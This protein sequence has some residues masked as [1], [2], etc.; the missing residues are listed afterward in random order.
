[1]Y[2]QRT[3]AEKIE[4]VGIGLHSGL[5]VR[6]EIFPAPADSGIIFVRSDLSPGVE[7]PA[8]PEFVV[9]TQLATTLGR[10]VDGQRV[11]VATVEHL[12]AALAG[13]GIDNLMIHVDGPEL[14]VM[15]GSSAPFVKLILDA[16][17]EEVRGPK[18]AMV[19]RKEVSVHDGKKVA[20]IAP[21]PG[22][23]I[24]CS[25]DFDH[26]LIS[27]KPFVFNFSERNFRNDLCG[28]RTFGF[29]QDV[30]LL[31]QNGLALG[32]SLDNAVVIDGFEIMN[33]EGL[34][35][36]DEFVRHKILDVIGDLS[37]IGMPLIGKVTMHC[38]GHAMNAR[39]VN[40]VLS[41]SRSYEIVELHESFERGLIPSMGELPFF[42]SVNSLA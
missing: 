10:I 38:S 36:A 17:I 4:F 39:L 1:M 16:G 20:K 18:R 24:T 12:L 25:L 13:L 33:P 40:A 26:P 41:D 32:G 19:I 28:A 29:A 34:R 8:R 14:P 3:I 21:G 9:D 15:D 27:T 22:Y 7:I 5:E 35:Y 6:M 2:K 37:L 11:T 23:E 30:E 31:R 42:E